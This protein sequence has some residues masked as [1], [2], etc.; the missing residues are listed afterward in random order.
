[1]SSSGLPRK[2]GPPRSQVRTFAALGDPTRLALVEMLSEASPRS[3]SSL[4]EGLP[5]TRQAI[6]KHLLVLEQAGVV[7]RQKHG[8]ES[9]FAISPLPLH[10]ARAYIDVVARQWDQALDRLKTFAE[11]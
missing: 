5:L 4:A 7:S 1:M 3:I 11:R 10:D 9:L 8:R 6:T 2:D